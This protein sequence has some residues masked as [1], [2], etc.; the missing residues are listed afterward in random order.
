MNKFL[1]KIAIYGL[2]NFIVLNLIAFLSLYFLGKSSFYKQQFVKNGLKE[3]TFDYVVLGSSTG[4]TTLDTKLIDSLTHRSGLNISIDDSGLSSHYI[5]LQH[6]YLSGKSTKKLIL[7]VM[8]DDLENEKPRL[9]GNDYRFLPHN[10]EDEVQRFFNEID[11]DNKIIYQTSKYVPLIGVSY[12]NTELFFP[13]IL[14]IFQ[15]TKRNLFDQ[16]GNYSYPAINSSKK[17]EKTSNKIKKL[18]YKNPYLTKII[19]FCKLNKVKLI[20]YQSPIYKTEVI[21]PDELNCVNQCSLFNDSEFFY[22]EIHVN[23]IGR[24]ICSEDFSKNSFFL[25]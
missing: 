14:S 5:M 10:N 21:F 9:N 12:F 6:F 3:T 20:L 2:A 23:S 4:L 13:G 24:R 11:G 7:A 16:N 1:K 18:E 8:P 19:D 25:N 22:D 15:P 17:L